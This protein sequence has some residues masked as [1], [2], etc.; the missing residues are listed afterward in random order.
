[1]R[2]NRQG[3]EMIVQEKATWSSRKLE[4]KKEI[5]SYFHKRGATTEQIKEAAKFIKTLSEIDAEINFEESF[6]DADPSY[7]LEEIDANFRPEVRKDVFNFCLR[8]SHLHLKA[9][10]HLQTQRP[11]SKCWARNDFEYEDWLSTQPSVEVIVAPDKVYVHALEYVEDLNKRLPSGGEYLGSS[12]W[13]FP[14]SKRGELEE[15]PYPVLRYPDVSRIVI[16]MFYPPKLKT[17]KVS[18]EIGANV[19]NI[20]EGWGDEDCLGC[21]PLWRHKRSLDDFKKE[22]WREIKKYSKLEAPKPGDYRT[23]GLYFSYLMRLASLV[24]EGREIKLLYRSDRDHALL[25][26]RCIYWLV[27]QK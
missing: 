6:P 9:L 15:L 7:M 23:R 26:K 27:A 16:E 22:L 14:L 4:L 20:S 5:I 11:W 24:K 19:F 3:S 25:I 13:E 17:E 10:Q 1:M 12:R 21:S 8:T 2:Q 18:F